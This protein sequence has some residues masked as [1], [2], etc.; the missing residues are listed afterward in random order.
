MKFYLITDDAD[1]CVGMRLAG[2]Y[3][4]L[5]HDRGQTDAALERVLG[6]GTAGLLLI[7]AGV[8]RMGG[9][10]LAELSAAGHPVVVEIPD[11]AGSGDSGSA[12]S[13][14]IR[15]TVGISI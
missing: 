2:V 10:R 6:D 13:D 11:S 5:V 15:A 7:T 1:T 4:F 3:S 12:V 14:Y 8:K 9:A